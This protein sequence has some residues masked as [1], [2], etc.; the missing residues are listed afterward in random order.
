MQKLA[1]ALLGASAFLSSAAIAQTAPVIAVPSSGNA[2]LRVGTEVPLKLSEELTTKDKKLKV[3]QR[4]R[5]ETAANVMVQDV[6]VIP[7][8]TPAVAEIIDV[9][10]QGG[11]GKSGHFGGRVL[12][13]TVNGR[14]VRM[15]GA[16]DDKGTAGG[17]GAVAAAS[18]FLP[19]GFLVK[20]T[21]ARMEVGTPVKG[22]IDEDVPLAIAATGPAPLAVSG[23]AEP[24]V[25]P[26]SAVQAK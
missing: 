11:W 3:G 2:T 8:G 26:V 4:V 24:A 23:Q 22:F 7:A 18:L 6:V 19:A 5:L 16:F 17:V 21:N 9:R 25:I 10:N 13:L 14:Q 20:G 15:S 1:I 12:Y